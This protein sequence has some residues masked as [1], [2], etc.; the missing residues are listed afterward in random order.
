M[1]NVKTGPPDITELRGI[2]KKL[3]S[4]KSSSD[5]STSFI[6]HAF[7]SKEFAMEIVKL[8][9]TVW[10]TK[11]IP[12]EWGH[13]RLNAIWKGPGKGKPDDASTYRG[14]QIGS[15][16]CKIMIII[17]ISRWKHWY[18][19]QLTDQQQGFRSARGTADGIFVA[20]RAQQITNK[21]KKPSY[22]L[23]VDLT[24]AF[25][26]VERGWMF[27]SI[28]SR[29]PEGFNQTLIELM[30]TLYANTTTALAESPND[31]FELI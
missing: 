13:S 23:F 27:K 25:D 3:K 22:V 15:S 7:D 16:L 4:G 1:E 19:Q 12:R 11:L 8:Y 17:I 10:L 24:A 31:I 20:K 30:E 9:R 28:R 2:I 21:M 6:K 5:V 18:E 14:L 29:C 26:H